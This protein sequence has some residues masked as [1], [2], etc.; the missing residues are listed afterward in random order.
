[1]WWKTYSDPYEPYLL[2]RKNSMGGLWTVGYLFALYALVVVLGQYALPQLAVPIALGGLYVFMTYVTGVVGMAV[3]APIM[4]YAWFC[5][6]WLIVYGVNP[7]SHVAAL[8]GLEFAMV[9]VVLLVGAP[10]VRAYLLVLVMVEGLFY[11]LLSGGSYTLLRLGGPDNESAL[12]TGHLIDK[13]IVGSLWATVA[14][15]AIILVITLVSA[16]RSKEDKT[17]V[18]RQLKG[19]ALLFAAGFVPPLV[20]SLLARVNPVL[21]MLVTLCLYAAMAVFARLRGIERVC[22]ALVPLVVLA[23]LAVIAKAPL[24]T[25]P[26]WG[27][28]AALLGALHDG[29]LGGAM[30]VCIM[31]LLEGAAKILGPL[32]V[33][34]PQKVGATVP[35][36]A[37][38]LYL[39]GLYALSFLASVVMGTIVG[40]ADLREYAASC[41]EPAKAEEESVEASAQPDGAL[42]SPV[43]AA[44]AS[45]EEL[46][47][48]Q[49]MPGW[50]AGGPLSKLFKRGKGEK[51][52]NVPAESY[53]LVEKRDGTIGRRAGSQ[54][55]LLSRE[56]RL[57]LG[58]PVVE[59]IGKRVWYHW[60]EQLSGSVPCF[61]DVRVSEASIRN[62]TDRI[63]RPVRKGLWWKVF[64]DDG[65]MEL[66]PKGSAMDLLLVWLPLAVVLRAIP[67]EGLASLATPVMLVLCVMSMCHVMGLFGT[68][69]TGPLL[70]YGW[71]ALLWR[72]GQGDLVA[73]ETTGSAGE[74]IVI[75]SLISIV[76]T[77]NVVLR[78]GVGW[79][80][81]LALCAIGASWIVA[82]QYAIGSMD[83]QTTRTL[84]GYLY[85]ASMAIAVVFSLWSLCKEALLLRRWPEARSD[86]LASAVLTVAGVVPLAVAGALSGAG[87][88]LALAGATAAY[89]A[90][91]VAGRLHS[92][93]GLSCLLLP[94]LV[95]A[96]A[97][98]LTAVDATTLPPSTMTDRLVAICGSG[99]LAFMAHG[100]PPIMEGCTKLL[101]GPVR[102]AV[103]FAI[104]LANDN[105]IAADALPV[106]L[107]QVFCLFVGILGVA[108][109]MGIGV[110]VLESVRPELAEKASA[111]EK[112]VL[113]ALAKPVAA[114]EETLAEEAPAQ[115]AVPA[116]APAE[117]A[118]VD[119]EAPG[120]EAPAEE[121]PLDDS[122]GEDAEERSLAADDAL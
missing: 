11:L 63:K 15:A 66:L 46:Q 8:E 19:N 13:W 2:F 59:R 71:T 32:L 73:L 25:L 121:S 91:A 17:E 115:E 75:F 103:A 20:G 51:P 112:R 3:L 39:L 79:T 27:P 29:P 18:K 94:L 78:R 41:K 89:I 111:R 85:L 92:P 87:A 42:E 24:D 96:A 83:E 35:N 101:E 108:S 48:P 106:D 113:D 5:L 34:P 50:M 114:G 49:L 84:L 55:R 122:A 45:G 110:S 36:D 31:S 102:S 61:E 109:L 90:L 56:L 9:L 7:M 44:V 72:I 107:L 40:V 76:T 93:K 81:S 53:V 37:L 28:G 104:N 77:L 57:A 118:A 26:P 68:I 62:L 21:G 80:M 38:I 16:V 120:E 70:V 22:W 43:T 60:D 54:K 98:S 65:R 95:G 47:E 4:S 82:R 117:A 6:D 52:A 58:L 86:E 116:D 23:T 1:M 69:A 30:A 100:A 119:E 64:E 10:Q 67:L 99:P 14:I 105:P 33:L 12:Q 97:W 88:L 74:A